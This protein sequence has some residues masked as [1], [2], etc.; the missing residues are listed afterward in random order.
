M[1]R[2]FRAQ[3]RQLGRQVALKQ[4][5]PELAQQAK[6]R[7]RF[8]R[9]ARAAASLSHPSI[10]QIHDI[11]EVD[12]ADWIIMEWLEGCPLSRVGSQ[13]QGD[14]CQVLEWGCQIAGGLACAHGQGIVHRDLKAENVLLTA[15][16]AIKVLDF[17]LAKRVD[18][19]NEGGDSTDG[20]VLGTPRVMSPEQVRG[21]RVD[22]KTD[23][24]A[25][26]VL[27]YELLSGVS[28]FLGPDSVATFARVCSHRQRPLLKIVAGLPDVV[29]NLVDRL[30]AKDADRRP[31]DGREVEEELRCILRR[32]VLEEGEPNLRV[33]ATP[34]PTGFE[35]ARRSG[36]LPR[37]WRLSGERRMVCVIVCELRD[38]ATHLEGAMSHVPLF[39]QWTLETMER[40]GGKVAEVQ[41]HRATCIFG[42]LS[43]HG[44]EVRRAMASATGLHR[45]IVARGLKLRAGVHA[46]MAW[47]SWEVGDRRL[48]LEPMLGDLVDVA[49][50]VAEG[51]DDGVVLSSEGRDWLSVTED[52]SKEI[53]H[54][55][56]PEPFVGRQRELGLLL[57][58]WRLARHGNFQ[59]VRLSG[60][61]GIGKSRL[62]AE[63]RRRV[64]G[65]DAAAR[66]LDIPGL[67]E[68]QGRAFASLAGP[69]SD[70]LGI[71]G[72]AT[73]Q[74]IS[75]TL[76]EHL[77]DS[78]SLDLARHVGDAL[79]GL[80]PEE[81]RGGE[82]IEVLLACLEAAI[83]D[84]PTVVCLDD[85]EWLDPAT[86]AWVEG[87][88][89]NPSPRPLLVVLT[90]RSS[91]T[92]GA[93]TQIGTTRLVLSRLQ[94][95]HMTD[96]A[97]AELG[98]DHGAVRRIVRLAEGVPWF[99]VELCR[100]AK[101]SIPFRQLRHLQ[102]VPPPI[103]VYFAARLDALGLA[104]EVAMVGA[105]LG[106]RFQARELAELL[107]TQ[108]QV[109]A[110]DL[111]RLVEA[112]VLERTRE[113]SFRF[114]YE[115]ARRAAA[116]CMLPADRRILLRRRRQISNS[117]SIDSGAG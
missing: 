66:W 12:G 67:P 53:L 58:R 87:L 3:D 105:T 110:Q 33:E 85:S 5:R 81:H 37:P 96:L 39:Q 34:Q 16:G 111:S 113:S 74:E 108:S 76:A 49:H 22:A 92:G 84:R 107:Q 71:G 95:H 79:H 55:S 50:D 44:D 48:R 23:L 86:M 4:I 73:P 1:G 60:G 106:R 38:V 8:L 83:V 11:L 18:L 35:S 27:L 56:G 14:W 42:R 15:T 116:A 109:L 94:D 115:L 30:L 26:G 63:L 20:R 64:H 68:T 7:Q 36:Q 69:V 103:L 54:L 80:G 47:V 45:Q 99:V 52:E 51:V 41:G 70:L 114:R 98:S 72:D 78:V 13:I 25:L 112:G 90:S 6:V 9:E 31:A 101:A 43:A 77:G 32:A 17:G 91:K 28:P 57:D 100:Q 93:G 40:F 46:G 89:D 65:A 24:F 82:I 10:V 97:E 102:A 62:L 2:V 19:D 61:R 104:K 75:E 21:Q 117:S 88:V 59:V 29:S